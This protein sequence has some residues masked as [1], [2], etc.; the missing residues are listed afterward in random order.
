MFIKASSSL[1]KSFNYNGYLLAFLDGFDANI[2][3]AFFL[4]SS[5]SRPCCSQIT[6][7][8]LSAMTQSVTMSAIDIFKRLISSF[9]EAI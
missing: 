3:P 9:K 1:T 2:V 8:V 7:K 4:T 5:M 6:S